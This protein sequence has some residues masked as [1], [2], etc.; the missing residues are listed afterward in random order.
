VTHSYIALTKRDVAITKDQL[1]RQGAAEPRELAALQTN[2]RLLR[3]ELEAVAAG[4][5]GEPVSASAALRR[6][7]RRR[8]R[9]FRGSA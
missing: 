2:V 5:A 9:R 1:E 7:L 4:Q 3:Q 8:L 6:A